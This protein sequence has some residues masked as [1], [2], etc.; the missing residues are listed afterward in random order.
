M[1]NSVKKWISFFKPRVDEAKM[2]QLANHLRNNYQPLAPNQAD[3]QRISDKKVFR[4][5]EI[6]KEIK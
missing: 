5:E 3:W 6:I 1:K 4:I 2:I